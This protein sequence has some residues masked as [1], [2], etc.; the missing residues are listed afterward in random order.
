MV[1]GYGRFALRE[2]PVYKLPHHPA[3]WRFTGKF[4]NQI[5]PLAYKL[6]LDEA[7]SPRDW[8]QRSGWIAA[9][10]NCLTLGAF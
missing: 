7:A 10:L 2:L 3:H 4:I 9:T 6:S 1:Q 8:G 5:A